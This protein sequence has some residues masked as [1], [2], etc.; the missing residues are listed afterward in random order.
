VPVNVLWAWLKANENAVY[1]AARRMMKIYPP[2]EKGSRTISLATMEYATDCFRTLFLRTDANPSPVALG[3]RRQDGGGPGIWDPIEIQG[4]T[5]VISGGFGSYPVLV[6][7]KNLLTVR[8][9]PN[10]LLAATAL[11]WRCLPKCNFFCGAVA[12]PAR[13]TNN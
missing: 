2:H 10:G 3:W 13:A 6:P 12:S 4:A 5:T 9:E 11:H 7:L 8:M 1:K